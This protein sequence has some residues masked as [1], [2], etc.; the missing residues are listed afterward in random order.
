[1]RIKGRNDRNSSDDER[2]RKIKNDGNNVDEKLKPISEKELKRTM[3]RKRRTK[4]GERKEE[5][6]GMGWDEGRGQEK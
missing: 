5:G 2:R 4:M 3:T 1:M 6:V